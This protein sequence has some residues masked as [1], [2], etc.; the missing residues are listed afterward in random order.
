MKKMDTASSSM[1]MADTS[2]AAN[3]TAMKDG[4]MEMKDGHMMVMKGGSWEKM[5]ASVKCKNGVEVKTDGEVSKGSRKKK[6]TE[7]MMIDKD[8]QMMDASGKLVDNAGW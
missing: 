5:T 6:L 8:G 7:G 3:K 1:P 4:V 2:T